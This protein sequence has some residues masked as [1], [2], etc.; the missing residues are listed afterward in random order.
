V[1]RS[2]L[3][4]CLSVVCVLAL[5]APAPAQD[6]EKPKDE[7]GKKK[8]VPKKTPEESAEDYRNLFKK[9]ETTV[10]YWKG[11]QF[12]IEVGRFDL[13]ARHLRGLLEKKPDEKDLLEIV[14]REGLAVFLRLR[15]IRTW[16]SDPK[17]NEQARKDVDDLINLVTTAQKK[18]LTDPERI[19]RFIRNLG[20]TPEEREYA[21]QQLHRSGAVAVPYLVDGLRDAGPEERENLLFALKYLGTDAVPAIL[22]AIDVPDPAVQV[23]LI[24]A[25]QDRTRSRQVWDPL[26]KRV[27]IRTTTDLYALRDRAETDPAPWWYPLTHSAHETVRRKASAALAD[28]LQVPADRLPPARLFLTSTAERYYQH[29]VRFLDP[30]HVTIWRWDGKRLV[31]GW[32]GV[33]AVT[34]SQAEQYYGLRFARQALAID[35]TYEPA[36]VVFLSLALEK[37]VEKAGLDQPLGK[38]APEVQDLLATVNPALVVA[39]LDR[40]L[41]DQNLPVILGAVRALGDLADTR[42]TLPTSAHGDS[43]LVRALYYPERRIQMAAANTLLRLPRPAAPPNSPRAGRPAVPPA[44]ARVVDVLRRMVAAEP[45]AAARPKVLIA[46]AKEDVTTAAMQALQQA[47][48]QPAVAHTGREVLQRLNAAADVDLLVVDADLPDPGL[49]ALLGQVRSDVN[50]GLLPVV[51]LVGPDREEHLRLMTDRYRNVHL[52]PPG[53][54]LDSEAQKKI[55]PVL[56]AEAIGAPLGDTTLKAYGERA[57]GWLAAMGRGEL[58]GYDIRPAGDAVLEALRSGRLG[59]E[60]QLWAIEVAGHLPG[61]RPQQEL[62]EVIIDPNRDPAV[63]TAAAQELVRHIQQHTPALAANEVKALQELYASSTTDPTVRANVALVM[64]SLRPSARLTG[65]RLEGFQPPPPAAAAAPKE[66]KLD[67]EEK[68]EP[69]KEKA[70]EKK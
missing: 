69:D 59:K 67:K 40:A 18:I 46:H 35:P 37:G 21:V 50:S 68:K 42:A 63:R 31:A 49:A 48:F 25:V 38:G 33:A 30:G 10:D 11:M 64:G 7:A 53:L 52:A 65:E 15:N 8:A 1:S 70:E 5:L 29:K 56:I 28:L 2:A 36:Q 55:L 13:A 62:A 51:V 19:G 66:E 17:E 47:G 44:P 12:E 41:T 23:E 45:L 9:P 6:E 16:S 4:V 61:A 27:V 14:D 26:Q 57:L 22:A 60:G 39:T 3:H 24:D 43:A 58:A 32:P 20:G 54:A 34:T